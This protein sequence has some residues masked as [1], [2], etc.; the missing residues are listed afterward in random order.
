MLMDHSFKSLKL[1][2]ERGKGERKVK[3][4]AAGRTSHNILLSIVRNGYMDLV[5]GG[6]P[7]GE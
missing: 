1:K 4:F 7:R 3:G 6:A 5:V 2:G